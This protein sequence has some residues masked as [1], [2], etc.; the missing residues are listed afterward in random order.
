MAMNYKPSMTKAELLEIATANGVQADDSMT[1]TAILAALDGANSRAPDGAELNTSPEETAADGQQAAQD[2]AGQAGDREGTEDTAG[3]E[4]PAEDAQEAP[5]GYNLFVYW[6]KLDKKMTRRLIDSIV[7]SVNIWL[8][9]LVN[10][11]KLLGGRVEFLEEENSET[12]L[13]AGKAV[14]HIYMTPPSPMKECEF[15]RHGPEVPGQADSDYRIIRPDGL[16]RRRTG[17]SGRRV[18]YHGWGGTPR[19]RERRGQ[20]ESV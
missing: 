2:G 16:R 3:Q 14:F 11:E 6:S 18:K 5:E 13:M 8:N 17:R 7:N 15:V 10:E 12:A 9:G 19:R 20:N 4:T 1:K